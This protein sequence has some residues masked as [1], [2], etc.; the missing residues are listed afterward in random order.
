MDSFPL[1]LGEPH[2]WVC[3][4]TARCNMACS[5]CIQKGMV[6]P[7]APRRPWRNYR[8]MEGK[9]WVRALNDLPVRPE[10]PLILTGGEPTLHKDFLEIATGLEGYSLDLTS[11]LAFDIEALARAMERAGKRFYS[12]FHTYS[13]EHMAPEE[14]LAR[15]D[16]L[17]STGIVEN[18]VF[19]FV[20]LEY[21]PQ[22]R[23]E[24]TNRRLSAVIHGAR[25]R[26]I[27]LSVN[28]FRANHLG[29]PFSR[30]ERRTM[31][32]SSAWV[33]LAPDGEIYNCQYHLTQGT[34]SFGNIREIEKVRPLPP[35]GTFFL[36]NDFGWCD[37]CHE[38]SGGGMF[39]DP[40]TGEIFRRDPDAS[41]M[42]YTRWLTPGEL[43]EAGRRFVKEGKPLEGAA[44]LSS[45]W[46]KSGD[47]TFL[48]DMGVALWNAGR[49][50]E[51]FRC[52][53]LSIE[54]GNQDP[55]CRKNLLNLARET[56]REAEALHLLAR[57]PAVVNR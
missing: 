15:A 40:T 3:I 52:F 30:E 19:S 49:P 42:A 18:P 57:V 6:L 8:E 43:L 31:E 29:R 2:V 36:C 28:E 48:N 35:L 53:S 34:H 33:N 7:S 56:G 27:P 17:L 38:N 10:H 39:R 24:D 47:P 5:Y 4:L 41:F 16:L 1:P 51:A 14:F 12:S 54:K 32:C 37:P 13:P 44:F 9:E 26:G 25:E 11:N 21:F 20:D 46:E 45:G 22:F 55:V 23:T 50:G